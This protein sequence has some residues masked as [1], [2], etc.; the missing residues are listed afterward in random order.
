MLAA[1]SQSHAPR[2][3]FAPHPYSNL[4]SQKHTTTPPT[5]EPVHHHQSYENNIYVQVELPGVLKQNISLE[6][7]NNHLVLSAKRFRVSKLSKLSC[8][9]AESRSSAGATASAPKPAFLYALEL[10]MRHDADA[11]AV[12]VDGYE[13]GILTIHIPLVTSSASR[14]IAIDS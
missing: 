8:A 7:H 10:R 13:D 3:P 2:N 14:K 12:R 6:I 9:P 4:L 5:V 11:E 1:N